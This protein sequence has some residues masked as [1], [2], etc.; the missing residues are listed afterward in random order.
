MVDQ[1]TPDPPAGA[2]GRIGER[3]K[4]GMESSHLPGDAE[5]GNPQ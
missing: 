3:S 4:L 1:A 5:R 2:A